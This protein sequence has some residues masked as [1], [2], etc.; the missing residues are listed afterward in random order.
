[1]GVRFD[2]WSHSKLNRR[3]YPINLVKVPQSTEFIEGIDDNPTHPMGAG[4]RQ[5]RERLVVAMQNNP[6]SRDFRCYCRQQLAFAGDV[7]VYPFLVD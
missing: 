6:L 7:D 1:M 3:Y 5:L 4:Q 2:S